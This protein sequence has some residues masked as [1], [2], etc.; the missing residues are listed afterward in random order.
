MKLLEAATAAASSNSQ[1]QQPSQQW[2]DTLLIQSMPLLPQMTAGNACEV[3]QQLSQIDFS[4][5]SQWME[6][7]LQQVC[8]HIAQLSTPQLSGLLWS[9]SSLRH[10]PRQQHWEAILQA[11]QTAMQDFYGPDLARLVCAAGSIYN[12]S[13]SIA[14][15]D[16]SRAAQMDTSSADAA[17]SRHQ[18]STATTAVTTPVPAW[19]SPVAAGLTLPN[20]WS[21]AVAAEVEYQVV[22]F[23]GDL[24]AFDVARL[25][26][27]L[28]DL[29]ITPSP[30]LQEAL[31]KGAYMRTRR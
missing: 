23:L 2:M 22:E 24:D 25:A 8:H 15:L 20:G 30:R 11:S 29:G 14:E 21:A 4:P 5:E 6:Q 12:S 16:L 31:L 28:A 13:N 7:L 9:L 1:Q 10:T 27:G 18:T 19:P 17:G 26:S 3:C